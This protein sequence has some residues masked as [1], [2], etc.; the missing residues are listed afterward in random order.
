MPER[1]STPAGKRHLSSVEDLTRWKFT[2]MVYAS[3]DI[4]GCEASPNQDTGCF[5]QP[6]CLV[7]PFLLTWSSTIGQHNMCSV[8]ILL[9]ALVLL[10]T[11]STSHWLETYNCSQ[12]R[13]RNQQKLVVASPNSSHRSHRTYSSYRIYSM[14]SD[15]A[16]SQHSQHLTA[17][18]A[19]TAIQ[20]S[21]C[22]YCS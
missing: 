4:S 15:L 16:Q 12:R 2:C 1:Q 14:Y 9:G 17:V 21:D 19:L 11:E 8:T 13:N 20:C 6:N 22:T 7:I 18:I 3:Q 5:D 10:P